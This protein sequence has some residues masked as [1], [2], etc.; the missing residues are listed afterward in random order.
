MRGGIRNFSHAY[1]NFFSRYDIDTYISVWD[2]Q[3][4]GSNITEEHLLPWKSNTN[5]IKYK[6]HDLELYNKEKE[7]YTLDYERKYNI[8]E[9]CSLTKH[10]I[11][12]KFMDQSKQETRQTHCGFGPEAIEYWANRIKDQ[13]YMIRKSYDLIEDYQK[14]D[15]IVRLR[16][17]YLFLTPFLLHQVGQKMIVASN[18]EGNMHYDCIQYGKP[19]VMKKYL[20]LYDH[21]DEFIP[22]LNYL[23]RLSFKTFNAES[24]M[25]YYMEE[26][27][28]NKF[29]T[30][31]NPNLRENI[32][33]ILQRG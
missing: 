25:K 12:A 22:N 11:F 23:G 1:H 27:G 3:E 33:F 32:N 5:L 2:K 29:K 21:I 10:E 16:F 6:I 18:T 31:M 9:I 7:L 8:E 24:M 13:Y 19:E 26:C 20:L 4:Y 28:D 30:H 17:D 15:L 14:Y